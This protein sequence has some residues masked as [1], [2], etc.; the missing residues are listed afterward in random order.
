MTGDL[1]KKKV[2]VGGLGPRDR[3]T[4]EMMGRDTGEDGHL[5]DNG[6]D[7]NRSVTHNPQKEPT[8]WTF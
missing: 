3:H 2:G 4:G 8:L 6:R 5:Q 1:I 7:Q